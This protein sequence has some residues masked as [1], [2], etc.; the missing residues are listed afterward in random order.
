MGY[1][2]GTAVAVE[3]STAEIEKLIKSKGAT[4]YGRGEENGLAI[5]RFEIDKI[6][7][8][9][10]LRL[11]T[12]EQLIASGKVKRAYA[13]GRVNQVHRELWRALLL[14]IKA[15]FVAVESGIETMQEAFMAQIVVPH[16]GRAVRF[17]S[18]ALP[19]IAGAYK[20]GGQLPPMLGMGGP[21]QIGPGK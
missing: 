7:F 9:F 13:A 1:A 16:E 11:P 3:K 19:A 4:R 5:V 20:T 17:A 14:T 6:N 15:K 10:E 12:A 18:V 2:D 8:M 21:P